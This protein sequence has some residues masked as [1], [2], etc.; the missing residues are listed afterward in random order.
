MSYRALAQV[1]GYEKSSPGGTM[2]RSKEETTKN[3]FGAGRNVDGN[4]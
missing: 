3:R 1:M 4:Q 2:T